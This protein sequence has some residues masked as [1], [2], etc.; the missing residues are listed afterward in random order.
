MSLSDKEIILKIKQGQID[1]FSFLVNKYT[2]SIYGFV[3]ARVFDK[4]DIDDIV[5]NVFIS[6]Y[7]AI[8][9][10]DQERPIKPYLFKIVS[11][12][13][14][15]YFRSKKPTV[16][17]TNVDQISIE[18]KLHF[19]I[20]ENEKFSLLTQEQKKALKLLGEEYSYKE[21]AQR[22]DRPLNTIKTIIRRARLKLAPNSI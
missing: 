19:S 5:Q 2:K 22:L 4:A 18:D 11:N 8:T 3:F 12:E 6:F 15:M 21:I 13:L 9:R 10:F 16:P 20:E 14:K 7:K 17:L 1:F